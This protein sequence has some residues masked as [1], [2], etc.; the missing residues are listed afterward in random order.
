MKSYYTIKE[1]ADLYGIRPDSLRYYEKIG[2]LK[3]KR[4]EANYRLY[5]LS[6]IWTLN[7]IR[8]CLAMGY[9]THR[10]KEYLQQ[11]TVSNT[12]AFLNEEIRQ[13]QQT[14][15][16]WQHNLAGLQA[17]RQNLLDATKLPLRTVQIVTLPKR[18]C[19]YMPEGAKSDEEVDFLLTKLSKRLPHHMFS[20]GNLNTGSMLALEDGQLNC[21]SVFIVDPQQAECDFCLP[22]GQYASYTYNGTY[23]QSLT[24]VNQILKTISKLGYRTDGPFLEFLLVDIHETDRTE[25]YLTQIQVN[26]TTDQ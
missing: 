7:I 15:E 2:L 24:G 20:I 23:E 6:D 18:P 10:I 13:L 8:D 26:I 25:E 21:Q 11:R 5:T 12:I 1:I 16:Q 17:R 9:D 14:I 4:S 22:E 19:W 3:P